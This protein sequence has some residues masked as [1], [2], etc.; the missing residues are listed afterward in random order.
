MHECMC[1]NQLI[2]SLRRHDDRCDAFGPHILFFQFVL[3]TLLAGY[4]LSYFK[5]CMSTFE[6]PINRYLLAPLG[7]GGVQ[8]VFRFG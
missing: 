1:T 5:C 7:V 3:V 4:F 2:I 6:R 8:C